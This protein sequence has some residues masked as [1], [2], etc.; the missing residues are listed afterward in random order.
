MESRGEAQAALPE[1]AAAAAADAGG[2]DPALLGEFLPALFAAAETGQGLSRAA[3]QQCKA[4]GEGAARTGTALPALLDLH[5]SASWRV[6][7]LLPTVAAAADAA[8]VATAGE[9]VLRALDE[10][11]A[12]LAAGYGQARRTVVR[13]QVSARREFVDDLLAG[14]GDVAG[15]LSHAP[16]FGL[17]LAR[18]HAVAVVH[19]E[20]PFSDTSPRLGVIER[21]VLDT[22][23]IDAGVL[24][25]TK[26]ARLVIACPV[27]DDNGTDRLASALRTVLGA[28]EP[29]PQRVRLR[30][31]VDVGRWRAGIGRAGLGPT[32]IVSSYDEARTALELAARL[33]LPQSVV[34]AADVLVY[35][36]L[37]R[38]RAAITDL[39]NTVLGPLQHARGGAGPLIDTLAGYYD[40]G[41]NAAQAARAMHLSVRALTYRLERIRDLTG[42][43]PTRS[44]QRFTLHAAVLG[45]QLLDWPASAQV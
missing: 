45:A 25:A 27:D 15:L 34:H 40:A 17:D 2:L 21:A 42:H 16:G 28:G 38:D 6:W 30:R 41:G 14:R 37:L 20:A 36:V 39:V 8:A 10:A 12:A 29:G 26:D 1:I 22:M 3:V 31:T 13:E 24:V 11:L 5:L 23:T 44:T 4:R 18:P 9:R 43:D 33:S 32:G 35:Q 7:R 19:A